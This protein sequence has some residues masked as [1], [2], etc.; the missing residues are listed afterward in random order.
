MRKANNLLSRYRSLFLAALFLA[1][2]S[3]G[4][5]TGSASAG[6]CS[7][8]PDTIRIVQCH[9]QRYQKA[10]QEL[11]QVYAEAMKHLT[12]PQKQKLKEAQRAWLK[13]RDTNFEFVKEL[14]RDSG[15]YASIELADYQAT[16]VEKRVLELK[17]LLQ[18]PA[19]TI[20]K[21]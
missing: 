6:D 12:E 21:W 18:G 10:D 8:Q 5:S 2:A 17:Y 15:T 4:W 19:G 7:Q 11:N 3:L 9:N 13:Y 1:L 14:N 16:M 20:T